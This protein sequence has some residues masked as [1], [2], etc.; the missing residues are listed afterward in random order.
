LAGPT[1]ADARRNRDRLVQVA[2]AAYAA[3]DGQVSLESIARDAGVG[4][5]TLYRHFPSRESLVEAVYRV[6]LAEV[7]DA[8]AALLERHSPAVALRRWMARYAEFVATKKGMA[9]TLRAV[10]D[11]GAMQV[12]DT[13]ENITNAVDALLTAGAADGSLRSDVRAEDVVSS[14][15]GIVLASGS[16]EQTRRMLD[17]LVD[18]IVASR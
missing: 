3:G 8:A 15:I 1:R 5:G 7:S 11:S 18:G 4:I 14:L 2:A 13:R 9:D 10:F 6:E 12:S 16:P 17:L